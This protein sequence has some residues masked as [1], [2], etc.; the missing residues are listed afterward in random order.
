MIYDNTLHQNNGLAATRVTGSVHGIRV[1]LFEPDWSF[2]IVSQGFGPVGLDHFG[3]ICDEGVNTGVAI[4]FNLAATIND[5]VHPDCFIIGGP[6]FMGNMM[7]NPMFADPSNCDF[8]VLPGS[9]AREVSGDLH[10]PIGAAKPDGLVCGAVGQVHDTG[11]G[12]AIKFPVDKDDDDDIDLPRA[13]NGCG[14]L[15]VVPTE[16]YIDVRH[17]PR[18]FQSLDGKELNAATLYIDIKTFYGQLPI[19]PEGFTLCIP[20]RAPLTPGQNVTLYRS[21]SPDGPF[22]PAGVA[23]VVDETGESVEFPGLTSTG[24]IVGHGIVE[25]YIYVG[26]YIGPDCNGNGIPDDDDPQ[27]C[28]H[29]R[30]L[31]CVTPDINRDGVV[32]TMDLAMLLAAW[33]STDEHCDLNGDGVVNAPD[34]GILLSMWGVMP[35]DPCLP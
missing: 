20:A 24:V 26:A 27:P 5:I 1:G 12:A 34:L 18:R 16:V 32:N 4:E 25:P 14:L 31:Q 17:L 28:D 9:A 23:G 35:A 11:S 6:P 2:N 15:T 7:G 22:M 30:P 19:G 13:Q 3:F 33:G 10:D 29:N 8:R 21:T